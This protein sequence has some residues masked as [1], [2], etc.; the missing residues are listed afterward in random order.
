[1]QYQHGSTG[2][3]LHIVDHHLTHSDLHPRKLARGA[4]ATRSRVGD[5]RSRGPLGRAG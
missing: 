4:V 3:V 2:P 1:V 5:P